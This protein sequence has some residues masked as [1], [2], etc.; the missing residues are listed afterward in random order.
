[1]VNTKQEPAWPTVRGGKAP[2]V[3]QAGGFWHSSPQ[4]WSSWLGLCIHLLPFSS[5]ILDRVWRVAESLF[6]NWEV[7]TVVWIPRDIGTGGETAGLALLFPLHPPHTSQPPRLCQCSWGCILTKPL[8]WSVW[9]IFL[10]GLFE[11][12]RDGQHKHLKIWKSSCI[13]CTHYALPW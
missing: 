13:I 4:I 5:L 6:P 2:W 8:E 7:G 10:G 3:Q 1:M 12:G 9:N 11:Y